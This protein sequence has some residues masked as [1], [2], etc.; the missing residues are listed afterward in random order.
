MYI[1]VIKWRR[2]PGKA[3]VKEIWDTGAAIGESLM[4]ALNV[5]AKDSE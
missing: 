1:L 5:N 3:T 2:K 4:N